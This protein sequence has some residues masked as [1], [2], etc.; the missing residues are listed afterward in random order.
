MSAKEKA[1]AAC[2]CGN[3]PALQ[4]L[5]QSGVPVNY[6]S[7]STDSTLLHMAAYCGQVGWVGGRVAAFTLEC[8]WPLKGEPSVV[9]LFANT[10]DFRET[11]HVFRNIGRAFL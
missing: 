2:C 6:R 10:E 9:V 5:L 1:M 8:C 11:M 3:V 7:G 4:A